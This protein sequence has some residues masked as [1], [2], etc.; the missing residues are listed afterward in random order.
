MQIEELSAS[1]NITGLTQFLAGLRSVDAQIDT[2]KRKLAELSVLAESV[3]AATG[4]I[5]IDSTKINA[6]IL[7]VKSG[8]NTLRS[9]AVEAG[10]AMKTVSPS[11]TAIAKTEALA[12]AVGHLRD[13]A[14]EADAAMRFGGG[15]GVVPMRFGFNRTN[16]LMSEFQRMLPNGVNPSFPFADPSTSSGGGGGGI[17]RLLRD[18]AGRNEGDGGGGAGFGGDRA[19]YSNG[20]LAG[21]LPGGARARPAALL[22]LLGLAGAVGVGAGPG[23]LGLG[24]AAL[25]AAVEGLVGATGTLK[26]AFAGITSAA[27]TTQKAFD[28]LDPIQQ[29]FVQSLRSIDAGFVKPL[30]KLAQTNLLPKLVDSLRLALSPSAV[31]AVRGTVGSFSNAIG[32][33]ALDLGHLFGSSGFA[34]N[35]G[36]VM[37]ADAG[38]LKDFIDGIGNLTDGLFV[39]QRAGIPF[40]DWLS[41]ATLGMTQWVD[42]S[43]KADA[44]NGRL[45]KFFTMAKESLQALGGL[46]MS[47]AHFAGAFA[48]AVGFQNALGVIDL[49]KTAI[50]D[51]SDLLER[52]KTVLNNFFG[53]AIASAHDFLGVAKS[54]I[55]NVLSPFLGFLNKII[56][57]MKGWRIV[58][59]LVVG[60][61][62]AYKAAII[63]ATIA[64]ASFETLA[65]GGLYA[66]L[67]AITVLTAYIITHWSQVTKAMPILLRAAV[68]AIKGILNG[69]VFAFL[70]QFEIIVKALAKAFGWVPFFGKELKGVSA[71]FSSWVQGFATSS[72]NYFSQ[73]GSNGALAFSTAFSSGINSIPIVMGGAGSETPLSKAP[74]I[75]M[76]QKAYD[77][78]KQGKA[79]PF[80]K[81]NPYYSE[82]L[83]QYQLGGGKPFTGGGS[84]KLNLALPPSLNKE[85]LKAQSGHGDIAKANAA[86]YAYY[87]QLLKSHPGDATAIYQAEAPYAPTPAFGTP[88]ALEQ[89]PAK[90]P[91]APPR[92][93]ALLTDALQQRLAT[94]QG[95]D[96]ASTLATARALKATDIA[97]RTYLEHLRASGVSQKEISAIDR[98]L[99]ALKREQAKAQRE[100]NK[101]M[102]ALH[103]ATLGKHVDSILGIGGSGIAR[104]GSLRSRERQIL[105]AEAK[106]DHML[107][108]GMVN[109]PL[110]VLIK[111]LG[112]NIPKSTLE[113]LQKINKVLEMGFHGDA[114]QRAQQS[115]NVVARLTQINDTLKLALGLKSSYIATS[116]HSLTAG[117]GLTTEQRVAMEMR[118]SQ[119]EAHGGK[120]PQGLAAAGVPLTAGGAPFTGHSMG[121]GNSFFGNVTIK[122]DA[123]GK[124]VATLARE[125]STELLKTSRR[126][127]VQTRGPNAGRPTTG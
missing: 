110:S 86:I 32:G 88:G 48:D 9:S 116:S 44:S 6:Q 82:L 70:F 87:E 17:I 84:D 104:V 45:A 1:L 76:Q 114:Q 28:K 120:K 94:A 41:K 21:I 40:T 92:G 64:T 36:A 3:K 68:D 58:I 24:A 89:D 2:T 74:P 78:G 81:N 69:M 34:A 117:L 90:K 5:G 122:I 108:A 62:V 52:N 54:I 47:V 18:F 80:S 8:I 42:Q 72:A 11:D 35:F 7:D 118:I 39:F 22:S 95:N 107:T 27:F 25:P 49:L 30:E 16:N 105:L 126:N 4:G 124:N 91:K 96:A 37:K 115:Q 85:L 33:G 26:L 97:A 20:A 38:Y 61:F 46:F 29:R 51:I 60:G 31:N 121:S 125:I 93:I 14:I 13:N 50:N 99:T 77:A 109:E 23:V 98:E 73:A 65:T 59:D 113:S 66:L 67:A 111:Q 101:D 79:F 71:E 100:I 103:E 83:Q 19:G 53:G 10:A 112:G 127:P 102:K 123:A 106:R 43:L 56:G 63:A 12:A 57:G 55:D 75:G 15:N 119:S